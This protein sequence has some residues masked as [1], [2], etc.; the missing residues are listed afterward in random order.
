[1]RAL[2]CHCSDK[3]ELE[4][5]SVAVNATHDLGCDSSWT[6]GIQSFYFRAKYRRWILSKRAVRS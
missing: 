6:S 4:A 3:R 5:T 1:M 2:L